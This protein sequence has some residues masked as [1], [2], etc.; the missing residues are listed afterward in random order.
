MFIAYDMVAYLKDKLV[1]TYITKFS[2]L[3][4]E[5]FVT[6]LCQELGIELM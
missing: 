2:L 5:L 1:K 3:L 4:E 6:S